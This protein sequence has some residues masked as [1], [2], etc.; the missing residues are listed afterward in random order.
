MKN[1]FGRGLI[2]ALVSA[3]LL[4]QAPINGSAAN[5][6]YSNGK[7]DAIKGG[8]IIV[9]GKTYLLDPKV[10]VLVQ[11]KKNNAYYE[12]FGHRGDVRPGLPVYIRTAGTKVME[13]IVER[14]KQ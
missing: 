1:K 7:I 13:I 11:T 3:L 4:I 12:T 5:L 14:W 2:T 8:K 9:S 10:R 6:V